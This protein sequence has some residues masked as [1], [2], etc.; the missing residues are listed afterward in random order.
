MN[1]PEL[2]FIEGVSGVGKSTMVRTLSDRLRD[3]GLR[4]RAYLEFDAENPIDFYSTA[5]LS[6]AELVE[7]CGRYPDQAALLRDRAIG[8]G[9]AVLVRYCDGDAPLFLPPLQAELAARE[10]CWHPPRPVAIDAYTAVMAAVWRDHAAS[11]AEAGEDFLLFDGSLLFHPLNDMTRNYAASPA[12][13][14]AHVRATLAAL[15]ETPW[16]AFY[17]RVDDYPAQL[18]RARRDRG[19]KPPTEADLRFWTGRIESDRAVLEAIG[20]SIAVC[21]VTSGR[22]A[23]AAG[24]ILAQILSKEPKE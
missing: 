23:A 2:I 18:A 9:A 8:A 20:E 24:E 13:M 10:L 22:W 21:D 4:V 6:R 3:A 12:R 17:L 1:V 19:Q 5:C 11:L 7:L 15:G 16:R 14:A